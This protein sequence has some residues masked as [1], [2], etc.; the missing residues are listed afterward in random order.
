MLSA[1]GFLEEITLYINKDYY[2]YYTKLLKKKRGKL[3]TSE[4][5]TAGF[6]LSNIS[7]TSSLVLD[8]PAKGKKKR[9]NS[10]KS[11][12]TKVMEEGREGEM[13]EGTKGGKDRR[14]LE[15]KVQCNSTSSKIH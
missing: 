2:Y 12:S 15:K 13:N 9:E 6:P 5:K 11:S 4:V 1:I 3:L 14:D 7:S 10:S 8:F